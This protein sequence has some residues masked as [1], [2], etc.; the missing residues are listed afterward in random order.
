MQGRTAKRSQEP[1]EG[2]N[3]AASGLGPAWTSGAE[4]A[5]T[6]TKSGAAPKSRSNR[7]PLDRP[8][9]C[10][11]SRLDSFDLAQS[12]STANRWIGKR[13]ASRRFWEPSVSVPRLCSKGGASASR[14][15]PGKPTLSPATACRQPQPVDSAV[16]SL[17]P[18]GG[19]TFPR[20][21]SQ[22]LGV[23][24]SMWRSP[25]LA[26]GCGRPST[27]P[28]AWRDRCAALGSAAAPASAPPPPSRP[29]AA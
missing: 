13:S 14:G 24:A 11:A 15:G 2:T 18:Q 17:R 26:P 19:L 22:G 23:P 4:C 28:Q 8:S 27:P 1:A 20:P 3:E 6:S 9:S 7:R 5:Q 29:K 10:I 16:R 12:I 21:E 25:P